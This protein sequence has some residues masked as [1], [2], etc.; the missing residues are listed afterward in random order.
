[1]IKTWIYGKLKRWKGHVHLSNLIWDV[2]VRCRWND[3]NERAGRIWTWRFWV[4]NGPRGLGSIPYPALRRG[5]FFAGSEELNLW[6][7]Q[8]NFKFI[9]LSEVH[10]YLIYKLNWII[11]GYIKLNPDVLGIWLWSTPHYHN[12]INKYIEFILT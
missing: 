1:M 12:L 9:Y 4:K 2:R 6:M 11:L 3:S 10:V 8:L 5:P 7:E